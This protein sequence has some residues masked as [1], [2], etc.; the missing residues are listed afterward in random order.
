MN[1]FGLDFE[2]TKIRRHPKVLFR[3]VGDEMFLVHPDGEQIHNLNP[4]AASLWR[5]MEDP[6]TSQDMADVVQAAFP[7]MARTKVESDINQV[8]SQLLN[9]GFVETSLK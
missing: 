2:S 1:A 7:I 8:V 6:I 4:M 3:E 5:L 9:L